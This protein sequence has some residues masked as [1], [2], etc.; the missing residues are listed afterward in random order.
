MDIGTI[1]LW[2]D[3]GHY[4]CNLIIP[5]KVKENHV[6]DEELSVRRNRE[7][8]V[9][10]NQKVIAMHKE[11]L[12][13][14]NELDRKLTND[15]VQ[16][17]VESYDISESQAR[18]VERYVYT[19][20][21]SFMGDYFSAIDNV[22]EMVENVLNDAKL[23]YLDKIRE[24]IETIIELKVD[25]LQ[26]RLPDGCC[27]YRYFGNH[28]NKELDC[29]AIDCDECKAIFFEDYEKE[30]RKEVNKKP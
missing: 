21:H 6:F 1:R 18:I 11:K 16:Y 12:A 8:A 3:N 4:N 24:Q 2:Y 30:V 29:N 17:I 5:T 26:A 22:A 10:H 20:K 27:P 9:E 23:E 7:M 19:E 14:Q 28:T 15:V 25:G 13:K